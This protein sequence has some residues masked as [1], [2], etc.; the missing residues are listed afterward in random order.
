MAKSNSN[1]ENVGIS[2]EEQKALELKQAMLDEFQVKATKENWR[3][4]KFGSTNYSCECLINGEY[5][6]IYSANSLPLAKARV[7]QA[8]DEFSSRIECIDGPVVVLDFS[9]PVEPVII[10]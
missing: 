1:V 2:V 5:K 8:I 6:A 10:K 7:G 3:I 4:V 9:Q